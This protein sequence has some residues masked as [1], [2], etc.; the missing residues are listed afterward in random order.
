[1]LTTVLEEIA[2]ERR[3]QDAKWGGIQHDENHSANDW[4]AYIA[5]HAGAAADGEDP[6]RFRKQMI[7]VAALAV[8][9]VQAHDSNYGE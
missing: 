7:R 1:M 6:G 4:I 3:R 5:K 9:A 2:E 8:A